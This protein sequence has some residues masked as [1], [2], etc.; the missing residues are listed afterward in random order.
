MLRSREDRLVRDHPAESRRIR[1]RSASAAGRRRPRAASSRWRPDIRIPYTTSVR[2]RHR[3]VRAQGHDRRRELSRFARRRSVPLATTSTRRRR[4]STSRARIRRSDRSGR[5]SPPARQTAHSLQVIGAAAGSR[6]GC[7][8]RCNT[9]LRRAAQRHR[10]AST[11]C[12]RTTTIWP[13]SGVAPISTSGIGSKR[14]CSSRR[15]NGRTSA[16][17]VSLASGRPYSLR[18]GRDDFNTGQTN[19]RPPGVARNTLR[20]AGYALARPALVARVRVGVARPA[21]M[22]P[23]WSIGVDAFNVAQSRELLGLY[24]QPD[25]AVFRPGDRGAAAAADSAV[26]GHPFLARGALPLELPDTRSRAP[27]RRRAPPFDDTQGVPS[28]VEGHR[29]A[30]SLSLARVAG[31]C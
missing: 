2:C 28:P 11:R 18:T 14:W 31:I 8:G 9:R 4:R 17:A 12:R 22:R 19:A 27:R 10:T 20:W 13:A 29:V 26:G 15:A 7:R 1:I 23:A 30:R 24:R 25:L 3:A 16:S 21:T 5:S 6:R